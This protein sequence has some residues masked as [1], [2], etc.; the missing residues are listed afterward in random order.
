MADRKYLDILR[1]LE[2]SKH[3]ST[4][5]L[6]D[7]LAEVGSQLDPEAFG[8]EWNNILT[9]NMK[10]LR[11][12]I[13]DISNKADILEREIYDDFKTRQFSDHRPAS[14]RTRKL[15][16]HILQQEFV[17]YIEKTVSETMNWFTEEMGSTLEESEKAI[18][19]LGMIKHDSGKA[20]DIPQLQPCLDGFSRQLQNADKNKLRMLNQLKERTNALADKYSISA[21]TRHRQLMRKFLR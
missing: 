4:Q 14:L 2:A 16:E 3:H 19:V 1:N 17:L 20:T 18:T 10:R 11:E 8:E 13:S 7:T 9:E 6:H 5:I 21:I 15:S 12:H